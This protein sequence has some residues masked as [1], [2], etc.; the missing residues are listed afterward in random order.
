MRIR[1]FCLLMSSIRSW[2][3]SRVHGLLRGIL[4]LVDS[5]Q[6]KVLVESIKNMLILLMIG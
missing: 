1:K 2:Q 4:T 3:V 6:I 5:L